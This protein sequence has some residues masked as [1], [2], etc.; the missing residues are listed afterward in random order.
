MRPAIAAAVAVLATTLAAPAF[1]DTLAPSHGEYSYNLL[2]GYDY[3]DVLSP[4]EAL[5][6]DHSTSPVGSVGAF[7]V[8][9]ADPSVGSFV[10]SSGAALVSDVTAS[11][12]AYYEFEVLGPAAQTVGVNIAGSIA[13]TVSNLTANSA[14]YANLAVVL[15]SDPAS[16]DDG[17]ALATL[18]YAQACGG[19]VSYV[20]PCGYTSSTLSATTDV[21]QVIAVLTNT[22]YLVELYSDTYITKGPNG[23]AAS[24]IDPTISLDTTD[25]AYSLQFSPGV[26]AAATPEPSSFVLLGTALS[27]AFAIRRRLDRITRT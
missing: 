4:V 21:N 13:S 10:G 17:Y 3:Q 11:S 7:F 18:L 9:G 23:G 5:G 14:A 12:Y 25:P 2:T 1:A 19:P 6:Y 27:G 24:S 26:L 20:T 16:P 22:P 15:P 8:G